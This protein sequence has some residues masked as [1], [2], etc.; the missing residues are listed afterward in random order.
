[1]K[2]KILSIV[3]SFALVFSTTGF[4]FA[5]TVLDN[6]QIESEKIEQEE[7]DSS[8]EK[9]E[10][11]SKEI[12]TEENQIK[13]ES[14][15][16][17]VEE[18]KELKKE[19]NKETSIKKGL[20]KSTAK[21]EESKNLEEDVEG[22]SEKLTI[23][24]KYRQNNGDWTEKT[25]TLDWSGSRPI[26][27]MAGTIPTNPKTS[28]YDYTYNKKWE[29]VSTG[30]V[31]ESYRV[32]AKNFKGKTDIYFTADYNKAAVP[33]AT[34]HINYMNKQGEWI[35]H[36]FSNK[37]SKGVSWIVKENAFTDDIDLEKTF[38][39]D[40]KRYTFKRWDPSL[41]LTIKGI[42]ENTDYYFTAQYDSVDIINLN[43]KY[44]DNI[45]HGSSSWSNQGTTEFY[46]R[47]FK[48]PADIPANYEFLYWE[49]EGQQFKAGDKLT[50]NF[51]DLKEDTNMKF[52][53]V[54][55]YQPQNKVI[56]HYK[57]NHSNKIKDIGTYSKSIDIYEYAPVSEKWFYE[58]ENTPIE[59]GT[60][61]P[62]PDKIKYITNP[63]KESDKIIVTNL[64]AKYFTVTWINDD[65]ITEL[66]KD[67]D[68]SYESIPSYEGNTPTK[69][70][71]AQ[72]TYTFIGWAPELSPVTK[73]ITY[74]AQ[75]IGNINKYKVI[76]QDWDETILETDEE[77]P[78]GEMPEYNDEKPVRPNTAQYSYEFIGWSPEVDKVEKEIT[79][80][81]QYKET[82][83]EYVVT[84]IDEDG[85]ELSQKLYPYGTKA[86][87][88]I[89]PDDPTK[90][91]TAQYTYSFV[92]WT[93]KI[94]EVTEDATYTAIYN[95]TINTYT[96]TW[97]NYDGTVLEKDLE[98]PYGD[99]PSYN[100]A[101][102]KKTATSKYTYKFINWN[103]E[104]VEVTKD[105]TYKA[106]YKATAIPIPSEPDPDKPQTTNQPEPKAKTETVINESDEENVWILGVNAG[107]GD[108][109][110][111]TPI[112][113]TK[114][115]LI[116]PQETGS[117]ALINLLAALITII[118]GFVL[119]VIY[120]MN[121]AKQSEE[122][123]E[124]TEYKNH[125]I[126][127]IISV[128]IGIISIIIFFLT[129]NTNLPMEWIDKWTLLM[130]IILIINII[131]A[132]LSQKKEKEV[133]EG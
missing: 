122:D 116:A 59:L 5:D 19:E 129:E 97:V 24:L 11:E 96:I 65:N 15:K 128:V 58:N 62:L 110:N 120:I 114:T 109:E 82:I 29:N 27:N 76:W 130:I 84:F 10:K 102:P 6:P 118:I 90:E 92:G 88:I 1:M 54:Y 52:T 46:T 99:F 41:P 119:I 31:D 18:Q 93:P 98:V 8:Q 13:E 126:K 45:A 124:E 112:S 72:Y 77:V 94:V 9:T 3:L 68:V 23:H 104:V 74:I 2:K 22:T 106:T 4:A 14:Q 48:T 34:I 81:A 79:Y 91:A 89:R 103:P 49:G 32:Y 47:T 121:K 87:N 43:I 36:T 39:F 61:I 42:T 117:W 60:E 83:N 66:E 123:S 101:T 67:L 86:E 80:T 125:G 111:Y 37:I 127:R 35:E 63:V 50:I 51:A 53:A 7:Q 131:I 28:D 75:Y 26:K 56:Y 100:S 85:A 20:A 132:I 33:V 55:N 25:A 95:R 69:E 38:D 16:E 70:K 73:D 12:S 40:G 71:T 133:E 105:A 115:P 21:E 17:E 113:K 107:E 57:V 44:I 30:L 64:Y 108:K 78:Y